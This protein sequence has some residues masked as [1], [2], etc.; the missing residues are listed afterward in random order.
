[1]RQ[2]PYNT[3]A[4]IRQQQLYISHEKDL[5]STKDKDIVKMDEEIESLK[6]EVK[7]KESQLLKCSIQY[8]NAVELK[9]EDPQSHERNSTSSR[10][11]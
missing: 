9:Q 4:E 11:H 8:K 3:K 10:R 6:L 2:Q 1:M 7:L 5:M